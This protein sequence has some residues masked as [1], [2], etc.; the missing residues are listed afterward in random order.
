MVR[1]NTES[2]EDTMDYV[3]RIVNGKDEPKSNNF[4]DKLDDFNFPAIPVYEGI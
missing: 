2:A 3:N 1:F 4:A